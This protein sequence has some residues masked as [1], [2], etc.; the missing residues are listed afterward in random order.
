MPGAGSAWRI[1]A[2]FPRAYKTMNYE[3]AHAT[4]EIKAVAESEAIV[5]GVNG[6]D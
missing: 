4:R 2:T 1:C 5:S 3:V 6:L